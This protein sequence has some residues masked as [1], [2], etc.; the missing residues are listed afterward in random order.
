MQLTVN[1]IIEAIH[2]LPSGEKEKIRKALEEEKYEKDEG[3]KIQLERYEK[4]K[5]WLYENK[6]NYMNK[7]VCLDGDKLVAV[8]DDGKTLYQ[9]AKEAGIEIPFIHHIVDESVP[10]GGW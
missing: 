3:L 6:A 1:E 5:K 7:W 8:D 2:S 9:K 10:F 4:A